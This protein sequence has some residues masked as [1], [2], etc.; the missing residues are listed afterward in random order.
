MRNSTKLLSLL[1]IALILIAVF[2]FT[3]LNSSNWDYVLP[4][5]P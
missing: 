2:L 3:D 5:E 4:S 1:V